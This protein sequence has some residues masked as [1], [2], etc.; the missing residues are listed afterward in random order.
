M[1]VFAQRL[2]LV[3][4]GLVLAAV[5]LEGLLRL[6]A[7]ILPQRLQRAVTRQERPPEPGEVRILCVGDSHTYGVGVAPEESYPAQLE[8]VLRARGVRARV[9]NAGVPGQNSGQVREQLQAK[10]DEYHPQVVVIWVGANNQWLPLDDAGAPAPRWTDGIRLFRL[11]R[12]LFSRI[13]GVS[14]DFRRDLDVANANHGETTQQ[15]GTGK[16]QLRSVEVTADITKQDLGPIVAQI[17]AAGATPVLLTYPVT[18]GPLLAAIDGAI[19]AAGAA[20]KV[21]VVDLRVMA[22]RHLPRVGGLLLPDMHPAPRMYRAIGWEIARAFVR[23]G[24]VPP[25]GTPPPPAAGGS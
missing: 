24:I 22:R 8:Q 9:V 17:R 1:K 12:L 7:A 19:V 20:D 2:L 3:T 10:L 18:L 25:P 4:F 13:E 21:R 5:A 15:L 16:R 23:D 11:A 6:A 14:G